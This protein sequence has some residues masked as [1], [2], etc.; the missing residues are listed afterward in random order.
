[1]SIILPGLGCVSI[2]IDRN[3]NVVF[4]TK[5]GEKIP[6]AGK[7][8]ETVLQLAHRLHVDLEGGTYTVSH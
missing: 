2:I 4:I 7:E 3:V 5:D 6:A 8:G 1:L